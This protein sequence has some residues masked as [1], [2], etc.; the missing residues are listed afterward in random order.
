MSDDEAVAD[1]QHAI[2]YLSDIAGKHSIPINMHLNPTYA[3]VGTALETAFREGTYAPPLL[4]HVAEAAR[5]A[6]GK[7]MSIFIGL[8]DEGLAVEGGSFL[9]QNNLALAEKLELFNR[10]NDYHILDE[11]CQKRKIRL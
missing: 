4:E 10:T 2:D 3:A 1:I 9:R 8:S 5:H 11:V 6:M 7:S